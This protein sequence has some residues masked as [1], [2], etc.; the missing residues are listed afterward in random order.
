[1]IQ[2]LSC[3]ICN[4]KM[5]EITNTHLKQHSLTVNDYKIKF[6]DSLVR[7][8]ESNIGRTL[9]SRDKTYEERYG[10]EK[11]KSLRV[12]RSKSTSKQMEDINQRVL[13]T[14]TS[15]KFK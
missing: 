10:E 1:M 8:P 3:L 11:G 4:K 6:P 2:L 12:L 15:G 14:R 7:D 13:R 9:A 5:K